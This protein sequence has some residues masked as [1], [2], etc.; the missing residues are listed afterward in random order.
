[1][2]SKIKMGLFTVIIGWGTAGILTGIWAIRE[3]IWDTIT[4]TYSW[5]GIH[6]DPLAVVMVTLVFFVYGYRVE[7]ENEKPSPPTGK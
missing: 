7:A 3:F 2:N 6:Q 4:H 5:V 1:M